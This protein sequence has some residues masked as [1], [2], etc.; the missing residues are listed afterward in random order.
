MFLSSLA[1]AYPVRKG[2]TLRVRAKWPGD[3]DG[4]SDDMEV[5]PGPTIPSPVLTSCVIL[6]GSLTS[7]LNSLW[8]LSAPNLS[9]GSHCPQDKFQVS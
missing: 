5:S 2:L 8:P 7:A 6:V 1:L 4:S 9:L 3:P